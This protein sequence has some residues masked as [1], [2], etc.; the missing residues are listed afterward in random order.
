M[1]LGNRPAALAVV[2]HQASRRLS[3]SLSLCLSLSPSLSLSLSLSINQSITIPPP[4]EGLLAVDEAARQRRR[5][6]GGGGREPI[7]PTVPRYA[8]TFFP[9]VPGE[10]EWARSSPRHR[11]EGS[12]SL[13]ATATPW[14]P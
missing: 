5:E 6:W 10:R 9:A 7:L 12:A 3:L 13:N 8:L 4:L 11:V 1:L 14:P 2:A